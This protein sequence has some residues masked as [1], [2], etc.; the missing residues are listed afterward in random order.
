M[1]D[2]AG[3]KLVGCQNACDAFGTDDYCCKGAWSG[4]D[5]C[6]P[7]K[8]P[9][10]YTTIF[11]AAEP[12]AYSYPFDDT[13]TMACKGSCDFRVTFGVTPGG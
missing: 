7:A 10:N 6:D 2:I 8:W 5:N 12:Y 9:V 3:G 1:Q 4:R 11:K 13:A